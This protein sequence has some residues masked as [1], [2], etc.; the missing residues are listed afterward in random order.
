MGL[1]SVSYT[2]LDVYKR[3]VYTSSKRPGEII[4]NLGCRILGASFVVNEKSTIVDVMTTGDPVVEY[5]L[6][7]SPTRLV[8]DFQNSILD[9]T[10]REIP[11]GDGVV[12]RIRLAQHSPMTVRVVPVSYTHLDVYKRQLTRFFI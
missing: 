2:H 9:T 4:V 11:V 1:T 8:M 6:L 5:M 12:E 10:E 7:S 3:Q